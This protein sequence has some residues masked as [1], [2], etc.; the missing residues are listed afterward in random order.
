MKTFLS[1]LL[2]CFLLITSAQA[3]QHYCDDPVQWAE[4]QTAV[5]QHPDDDDLLAVYALRLGLCQQIRAGK[6]EA[7]RAMNIFEDFM[8][9]LV[10][11]SA[12]ASRES[13]HEQ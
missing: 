9:A 3:Q 5:E 2:A 7:N 1:W 11:K 12:R 4:W 8:A 6:L 13:T 10:R